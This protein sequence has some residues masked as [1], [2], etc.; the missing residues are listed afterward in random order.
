MILN[1]V[2]SVIC[3][4]LL[5]APGVFLALSSGYGASSTPSPAPSPSAMVSVSPSPGLDAS[6]VPSPALNESPSPTPS[7]S[8]QLSEAEVK[9]LTR[10][11][12]RAQ[13]NELRALRHQH[14]EELREL[15]ASHRA[16]YKEWKEKEALALKKYFEEHKHGP[17]RR[18][19]VKDR[20]SRR[21][22]LLKAHAEERNTRK[23]EQEVRFKAV[24]DDQ[25]TKRNEFQ[26]FLKRLERPPGRLWP[27]SN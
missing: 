24:Q 17:D 4:G 3:L 9:E 23:H 1:R 13:E 16:R 27:Q 18:A 15:D 5:A 19:Y 22:A 7:V 8:A 11:F 12:K 25:V 6:P 21:E 20:A 14:R 2:Y 26:E 10:N